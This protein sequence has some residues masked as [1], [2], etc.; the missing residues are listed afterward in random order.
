[1]RNPRKFTLCPK[2]GL[3]HPRKFTL[4][5]KAGGFVFP[6]IPDR[7]IYGD[8]G[9]PAIPDRV[10]NGVF[11]SRAIP[12]RV[13]YGGSV[14]PAIPDRVIYGAF[15]CRAIPDRGIYGAS[16]SWTGDFGGCTNWSILLLNPYGKN[17]FLLNL[18]GGLLPGSLVHP[19]RAFCVV[20]HNAC[21]F[22]VCPRFR[23][24]LYLTV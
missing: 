13:I 21:K 18:W 2:A 8:F 23:P 12:D 19:S 1:M 4:C 16:A 15:A 9:S 24:R 22:T 17:A 6:A 20:P 10:F 11:A 14:S 3:H 7:C 5:P